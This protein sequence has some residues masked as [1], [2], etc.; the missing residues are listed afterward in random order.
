VI[1]VMVSRT[2]REDEAIVDADMVCIRCNGNR[3]SAI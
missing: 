2:T 3:R 1:D